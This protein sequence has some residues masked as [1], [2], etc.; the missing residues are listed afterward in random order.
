[1]N[2]SKTQRGEQYFSKSQ[3]KDTTFILNYQIKSYNFTYI[4]EIDK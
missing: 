1:M 2:L 4:N 3:C